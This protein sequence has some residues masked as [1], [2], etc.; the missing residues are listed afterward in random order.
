MNGAARAGGVV[1][2]ALAL[3]LAPVG[4]GAPVTHARTVDAA[5]DLAIQASLT[6]LT[7]PVELQRRSGPREAVTADTTVGVGD[8]IFT[9]AGGS[10]R[11]TFFEG[12]EVEIAPEAEMMVQEMARAQGGATTLSLGQADGSMIARVAALI[13]PGSRVQLSTRSAV[14]VVRGT[15]VEV[16]VLPEQVQVFIS[17]EGDFDVVAGGVTRPV[18]AGEYTVIAPLPPPPM[19]ALAP[20]DR[21]AAT[22]GS[23]GDAYTGVDDF[24]PYQALPMS[25]MP[26]L[27]AYVNSA[28]EKS[29]SS[30]VVM[31]PASARSLLDAAL[32][33][34]R[35]PGAP[36]PVPTPYP[37][38]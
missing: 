6:V 30:V 24:V 13:N 33:P 7:A 37:K 17:N 19:R 35:P 20:G 34:Q 22:I 38:G 36:T 3:V 32:D 8:R 16:T 10:A 4:W 15:E 29:G 28:L 26:Y 25:E 21:T 18:R 12:T 2:L 5:G 14:A 27:F 11:L 9:L 31:P 23:A 1:A